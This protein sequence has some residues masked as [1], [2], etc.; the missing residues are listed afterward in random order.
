MP[1]RAGH[2]LVRHR[3]GRG[4]PT[5]NAVPPGLECSCPPSQGVGQDSFMSTT[6]P[7]RGVIV[8]GLRTRSAASGG[9]ERQRGARRHWPPPFA[10]FARSRLGGQCGPCAPDGHALPADSA[11]PVRACRRGQLRVR[12]WRGSFASWGGLARANRTEWVYAPILPLRDISSGSNCRDRYGFTGDSRHTK[13]ATFRLTRSVPYSGTASYHRSARPS[14]NLLFRGSKSRARNYS[15]T[16]AVSPVT[17]LGILQRVR[18]VQL[19]QM[20][21]NPAPDVISRAT[22]WPS[23]NLLDAPGILSSRGNSFHRTPSYLP[24]LP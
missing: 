3:S 15:A 20:A 11:L 5:C 9:V 10:L 6:L 23:M 8:H 7:G 12:T 4:V 24:A 17:A 18:P 14:P 21:A 1:R 19:V 22:G 13:S 16:S 2:G